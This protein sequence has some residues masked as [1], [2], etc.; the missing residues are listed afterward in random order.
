MIDLRDAAQII[1]PMSVGADLDRVRRAPGL[2]AM[3]E[4]SRRRIGRKSGRDMKPNGV[5]MDRQAA[6]GL[7]TNACTIDRPCRDSM[8]SGKRDAI[9]LDWIR[10]QRQL[11]GSRAAMV[12]IAQLDSVGRHRV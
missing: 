5:Q 4:K 3:L 9:F 1:A 11:Q 8:R 2:V 7:A 10:I 12:A 6:A